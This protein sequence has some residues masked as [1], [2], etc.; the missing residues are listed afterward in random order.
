SR[1]R[2]GSNDRAAEA[3]FSHILGSCLGVRRALARARRDGPWMA[4]GPI[5]PGIRPTARDGIFTVGNAAGEAHP[6][7]AEG[8]TMAIQSGFLLAQE[9]ILWA[10]AGRPRP[11]LADL[12]RRYTA[13]WRRCFRLRLR[14]AAA[15]A[16]WA[17]RPLVYSPT[18]P[19]LGCFPGMLTLGARLA[20]KAASLGS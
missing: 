14:T 7:V 5:Q 20:G 17:M 1:L 6:V 4:S 2:G 19:L 15:V 16:H 12:G 3:V 8:I 9:L 11:S 18:L 10:Q 13:A